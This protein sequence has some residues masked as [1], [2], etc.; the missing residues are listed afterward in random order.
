M[1]QKLIILGFLKQNAATGYDIKKFIRKELGVFSELDTSSIYYPLKKMEQEKLIKKEMLRKFNIKKYVYHITPK[2]EKK[3]LNLCVQALISKKRPFIELDI[4]LYFLSFL[5][6]KEIM[7]L[8]RLRSRFLDNVEKWLIS[9]RKELKN[10]PYNLILLVEHHL[11]L[12]M[13]EKE[14][15][16][17]IIAF[18]KKE[19]RIKKREKVYV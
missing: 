19:S 1:I 2:G 5:D 14:F 10:S 18:I 7:P 11:K 16:R 6:K 13:A 8:L 17:E 12:A 3:F 4:P 9:K 15:V